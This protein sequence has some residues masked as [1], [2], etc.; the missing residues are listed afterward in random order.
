[1]FKKSLKKMICFIKLSPKIIKYFGKERKEKSVI[2]ALINSL[3]LFVE[4]YVL[5]F[6]NYLYI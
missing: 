3:A 6:I 4:G 5:F 1:M 2:Q